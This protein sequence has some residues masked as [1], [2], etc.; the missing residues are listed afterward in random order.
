MNWVTDCSES[1]LTA[2]PT[3]E[4]NLSQSVYVLDLSGN[5]IE[6]VETFPDDIRLRSLKLADNSLTKVSH[7]QY[8]GL[9][10]LLDLDLSGNR[11]TYIEPDS[12]T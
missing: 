8:A 3:Y 10:F 2:V 12:F 4:E 5:H 11:I 7:V 6:N 1:N 9:K